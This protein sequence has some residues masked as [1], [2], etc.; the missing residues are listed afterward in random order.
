MYF[1][2]AGIEKLMKL[3]VRSA[4]KRLRNLETSLVQKRFSLKHGTGPVGRIELPQDPEERLVIYSGVGGDKV[5]RKF[6]KE[7][8]TC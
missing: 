5:K 6:P 2:W 3:D 8:F 1:D 4:S 7:I